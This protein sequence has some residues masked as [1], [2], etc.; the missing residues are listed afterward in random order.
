MV[1]RLVGDDD[2]VAICSISVIAFLLIGEAGLLGLGGLH[3]CPVGVYL[4]LAGDFGSTLPGEVGEN[5]VGEYPWHAIS[6]LERGV[7]GIGA[8]WPSGSEGNGV[9]GAGPGIG[10]R[11]MTALWALK[12]MADE[13]S[14]TMSSVI[15]SVDTT[16]AGLEKVSAMGEGLNS[17]A[18]IRITES[19]VVG[20][21]AGDACQHFT[22]S[23]GPGSAFWANAASIFSVVGLRAGALEKF[24]VFLGDCW[25]CP[26]CLL[27]RF[28]GL[29]DLARSA[30]AALT[31]EER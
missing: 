8:S 22:A 28:A 16:E 5:L 4:Y 15:D 19:G 26:C 12:T 21:A 9:V 24:G 30:R 14:D 27:A 11:M 7:T 17:R 31:K 25:C 6:R 3:P 13:A 2:G 10:G 20:G 1:C 29:R 18:G 23:A